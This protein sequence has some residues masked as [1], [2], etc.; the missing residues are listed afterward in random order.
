MYRW[1]HHRRGH[2][3][4]RRPWFSRRRTIISRIVL[5]AMPVILFGLWFYPFL[6]GIFLLTVYIYLVIW[7]WDKPLR[8]EF[9]QQCS[10]CF[11][12]VGLMP[13]AVNE[14]LCQRCRKFYPNWRRRNPVMKNLKMLLCAFLLMGF[15]DCGSNPVST[16][17]NYV[18]ED[19]LSKRPT[20]RKCKDKDGKPMPCPRLEDWKW[21]QT[22]PMK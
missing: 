8:Y 15:V 11:E 14:Y 19:S 16:G 20:T 4:Q 17:E 22:V 6:S 2:G 21:I 10:L 12:T 3:W 5:L 9:R 13:H 1:K 18:S 7:K